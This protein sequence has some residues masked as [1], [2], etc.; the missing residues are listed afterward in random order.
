[1]WKT[2]ENSEQQKGRPKTAKI[3][4][5][6]LSHRK[7]PSVENLKFGKSILSKLGTF[8]I[9]YFRILRVWILRTF[10]LGQIQLLKYYGIF[11]ALKKTIATT[12]Y[13]RS[14]MHHFWKK[15]QLAIIKL[16]NTGKRQLSRWTLDQIRSRQLVA[17]LWKEFNENS[18]EQKFS[19]KM[20]KKEIA[21]K[22]ERA[23]RSC[24]SAVMLSL[25]LNHLVM[26]SLITIRFIG[27]PMV[28]SW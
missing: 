26:Q 1:M 9:H 23:Q 20:K 13:F 17:N 25:R 8:E 12:F 7:L 22:R 11:I 16:V 21:K 27:Y 10:L 18:S 5:R 15:T 14:N 4:T 19:E 3:R 24:K 28:T 6:I 2:N